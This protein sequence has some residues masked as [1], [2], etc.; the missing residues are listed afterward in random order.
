M[1]SSLGQSRV[2]DL[3]FQVFGRSLHPDWFAVRAHRRVA[4]DSWMADIRIIEGGHAV[5]WRAGEVRLSG[6]VAQARRL[7]D[8]LA[9]TI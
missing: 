6:D 9:F 5:L 8:H 2:A 1:S 7:V 4:H 3:T